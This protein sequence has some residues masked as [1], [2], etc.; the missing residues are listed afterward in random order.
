MCKRGFRPPDRAPD[1]APAPSV[2]ARQYAEIAARQGLA[3]CPEVL[4]SLEQGTLQIDVDSTQLSPAELVAFLRGRPPLAQLLLYRPSLLGPR[5]RRDDTRRSA[6]ASALTDPATKRSL[7]ATLSS[8]L[9]AKGNKLLCLDLSGIPLKGWSGLEACSSLQRLSVSGCELGNDGL[10]SLRPIAKLRNLQALGLAANRLHTAPPLL[11][12]LAS[13]LGT[14]AQ[15]C[16]PLLVLD[17]SS[18]PGLCVPST[19]GRRARGRPGAGVEL[20]QGLHALLMNGLALKQ[21]LLQRCGLEASTVRLLIRQFQKLRDFQAW[22]WTQAFVHLE[23]VDL[24][25]N[26][27]DPS[28]LASVGAA[29]LERE[30]RARASATQSEP[31]AEAERDLDVRSCLSECSVEL[32]DTARLRDDWRVLQ[33][34][35]R[36]RAAAYA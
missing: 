35:L 31:D 17:V 30:P 20:V 34:L 28:L 2:P 5:G 24:R 15:R 21:L 29:L 13:R 9:Q 19:T 23:R 36:E 10:Q 25:G 11:R 32:E 7:L 22:G 18:N 12:L 14:R 27:L 3:P 8:F 16:A 26:G 33:Q 4:R 6:L 1:Y